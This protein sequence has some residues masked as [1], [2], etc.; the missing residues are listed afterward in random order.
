MFASDGG[1]EESQQICEEKIA[2][3]GDVFMIGDRSFC[4]ICPPAGLTR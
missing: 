3:M 1:V 4:D 2:D